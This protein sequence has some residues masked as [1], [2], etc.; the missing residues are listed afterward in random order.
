MN[1]VS[2]LWDPSGSVTGLCSN[3]LPPLTPD[4]FRTPFPPFADATV[5][6]DALIQAWLDLAPCDPYVW[7]DRYQLGM[8]LWTAHELT[9]FGP[10]GLAAAH[11]PSGIGGIAQ[12][13]AVN[14]VS[15]SYDTGIGTEDGAGQ[16]NMTIYGRQFWSMARLLGIG[17][18]MQIG[19]ATCPPPGSG[20]A[21]PGPWPWPMPGGSGFSS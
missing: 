18:P 1:G 16:Y 7:C 6:S 4:Q 20:G 15:V 14:G 21:W 19:A 8:G 10:N 9:K 13:K 17:S 3:P 12:S 5:Y 2:G 11:A